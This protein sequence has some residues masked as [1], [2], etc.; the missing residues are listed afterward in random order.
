MSAKDSFDNEV[1][2]LND[3][4]DAKISNNVGFKIDSGQDGSDSETEI[5]EDMDPKQRLAVT[6]M[7]WA[8]IPDNDHHMLQVQLVFSHNIP[9][10][11][12]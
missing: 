3:N 12:Q 10:L 11:S 8:S 2:K 4:N 7:N 6:L 1:D 9:V 5:T